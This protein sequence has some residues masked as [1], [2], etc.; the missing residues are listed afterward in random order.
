MIVCDWSHLTDIFPYLHT[1]H[2]A[3]DAA[4]GGGLKSGAEID[5]AND[6]ETNRNKGDTMVWIWWKIWINQETFILN[7][8]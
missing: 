2:M 6:H 5:L 4:T 3:S 7:K 1:W 8:L